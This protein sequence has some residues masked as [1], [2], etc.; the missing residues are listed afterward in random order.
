MSVTV[1]V[2]VSIG[3][4]LCAAYDSYLVVTTYQRTREI[5][6]GYILCVGLLLVASWVVITGRA[7]VE[8]EERI[9]E[10]RIESP[11]PTGFWARFVA[12]ATSRRATRMLARLITI[13]FAGCLIYLW[14]Q[15]WRYG[16][17]PSADMA[18]YLIMGILV[19][20]AALFILYFLPAR[21]Q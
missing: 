9:Y 4:T 20:L 13:L 21:R 17:Y 3:L 6:W 7:E 11:P 15:S 16:A 12:F 19:Y 10:V 1:R 5:E 2:I 8:E 18:R 14:W